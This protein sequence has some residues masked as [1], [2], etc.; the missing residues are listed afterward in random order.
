MRRWWPQRIILMRIFS[1]KWTQGSPT[2]QPSIA[3]WPHNWMAKPRP[4]GNWLASVTLM[5]AMMIIMSSNYQQLYDQYPHLHPTNPTMPPKTTTTARSTSGALLGN[6][7][8]CRPPTRCA[9][10]R[11]VLYNGT[12][13]YHIRM[14]SSPSKSEE[15]NYKHSNIY[16]RQIRVNY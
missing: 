7:H 16:V 15:Y 8:L 4:L 12:T 9:T 3:L 14:L 1:N 10:C 5:I 11:T 6:H 13:Q 2:G